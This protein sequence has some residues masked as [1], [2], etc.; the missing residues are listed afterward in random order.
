M[1]HVE[2]GRRFFFSFLYSG[3]ICRFAVFGFSP[4]LF[5]LRER[6]VRRAVCSKESASG[7]SG[8]LVAVFFAHRIQI[9]H[10]NFPRIEIDH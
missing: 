7:L 3:N 10:S 9:I 5:W 2:R 6:F 8:E 1:R 4:G